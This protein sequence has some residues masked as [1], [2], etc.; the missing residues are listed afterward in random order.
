ME[1]TGERFIPDNDGLEIEAEHVHRYK[2]ISSCLKNMN[3]LDA[4][5]GTGYGSLLMS[6][7]AQNVT[8]I[9]ISHESV[10]W[11][12]EHYS[13]QEN[14][15]FIQASLDNLPFNDSE[16]DCLVIFE[17]IE[18]VD[19]DIQNRFLKEARRV[20][21]P[22]GTLIISTPNK[23]V[24]TDKSGYHNPYHISEFYLD[25]FKSFLEQEFK[26][27]KLYNQS[28]YLVSSITDEA[29]NERR[30]RIIKNSNIDADGKYMIAL[31]S[32]ENG[33]ISPFDLGSV[34]KYDSSLSIN[35]SSL[36]ASSNQNVY[37]QEHKQSTALVTEEN[38]KFSVNF[39]ISKISEPSQFRFDPVENCFCLC[40][41][42]EV[43][44][45]GIVESVLPLN[46]LKYYKKGFLFM[47]IDPQ[48]EIKGNFE[49]ATYLTLKGYFKIMTQVE[50]SE[51]VD[52]IYKQMI[53]AVGDNGNNSI[54]G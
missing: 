19:K 52:D 39:D 49:H 20:L 14:L 17:V 28:L 10:Q 5:C 30:V 45:D 15:Q 9:D 12:N 38:N 31:C 23:S 11:C 16:F 3:V 33:A 6:Q 7:Y 35:M 18:H 44:T 41:I 51:I 32:N 21:K 46:A 47:N 40:N 53:A 22:N 50:I 42:E 1:Y 27:V 25:D 4:G 24:Y 8:G 48:F 34:Y 43:L 54:N 36:Y 37:S 13:A 2:A 29:M 26:I